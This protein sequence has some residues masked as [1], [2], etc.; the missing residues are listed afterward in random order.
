[1]L[2]SKIPFDIFLIIAIVIFTITVSQ[3]TA[4]GVIIVIVIYRYLLTTAVLGLLRSIVPGCVE[5]IIA[6]EN[7][8]DAIRT[9]SIMVH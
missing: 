6:A 7:T 9:W 4:V 5:S 2:D 3:M 1:M 8:I